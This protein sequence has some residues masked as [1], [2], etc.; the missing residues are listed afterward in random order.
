MSKNSQQEDEPVYELC[1]VSGDGL[2][3]ATVG[4]LAKF[5]I[6]TAEPDLLY[7]ELAVTRIVNNGSQEI[8]VEYECI[9]PNTHSVSYSPSKVGEYKISLKWK[10]RH[11]TGSPFAVDV[12]MRKASAEAHAP[13]V[14]Q[15]EDEV[16]KLRESV[17]E[18]RKLNQK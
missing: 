17:K 13:G 3:S 6:E 11:V 10:G 4:E 18:G 2:N 14:V 7:V 8:P 1:T 16:W 12:R 5:T 15:H 9:G